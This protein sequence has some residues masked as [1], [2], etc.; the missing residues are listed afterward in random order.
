MIYQIGTA[1][2]SRKNVRKFWLKLHL[3]IALTAGLI[4]VILGLTGSCNVFYF[5][6]GEFG[7]PVPIA[8]QSSQ[9]TLD[10]IMETVKS[11]NPQRSGSWVMVLPGYQSDYLWVGYPKPDETKDE[12]F[13][14]LEIL[15]DPYSGN[16]VSEHFWGQTFLSLIYEL[17][18][19]FLTGKFGADVGEIGFKI[20][21]FFGAF[22]FISCLSGIYLWWPRGGKLKQALTVKLGSSPQ[23]FYFDLH[24]TAGIYGSALLLFIAF[25]GFVFGY[26]NYVKPLVS[27]FSPVKPD[28]LKEP[29]LNSNIT[30]GQPISIV[31]AVA[32]ADKVFPNAELRGISTPD[33][34]EGV[35]MVAKRQ[36]GE[37]N[38]RR[39]RS[40]VWIDQ[41]SGMV[42]AV[43]DPNR[44]TTGETFFNLLW[45]LHDGQV[46]G[47]AGRILWCVSGFAPLILYVTGILRWMQ[48]R[49]AKKLMYSGLN[50]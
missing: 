38:R 24:K 22:L 44:F 18:A 5:E 13:A 40:K 47:I 4:L 7:L 19:D 29:K 21:S 20:V 16:I 6:L 45:P 35:Y 49:T 41:Y 39:P 3:A 2:V 15:V 17:H 26:D 14:P 48:K 27:F 28:H 1:T 25:T 23:R 46:L 11:A 42:L 10:D 43:Q 9:P 8:T 32:V 34:K 12:L 37:A 36:A 33:G 30:G 50:P 31:Q